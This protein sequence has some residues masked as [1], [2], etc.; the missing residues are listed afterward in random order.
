LLRD[1]QKSPDGQRLGPVAAAVRYRCERAE[2]FEALR[3]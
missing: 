3:R 1:Q 2:R